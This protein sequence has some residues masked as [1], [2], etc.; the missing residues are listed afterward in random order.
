MSIEILLLCVLVGITLL[1]YLVAINSHG[2]T[3]LSVSYM[4][5]TFLL[6]G[7]VWA[8]VQHVN[9]GLSRIQQEEFRRLE[10]EKTLAEERALSQGETL[11]KNKVMMDA[12]TKLNGIVNQGS[13]YASSLLNLEVR[14]FSVELDVLMT[15][16]NA[17]RSKITQLTQEFQALKEETGYFSESGVMITEALNVLAEAVKYYSLYYKAE[18]SA[19][20]DLRERSMRQKA[21]QAYDLFK[22]AGAQIAASL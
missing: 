11:Q 17:V 14:D 19:Q 16:A 22:K 1:A 20:E 2:T 15:R 4:I 21:S 3:R 10:R 7:T 8:I 18:D 13:N 6:A 5:A 9:S 12:A